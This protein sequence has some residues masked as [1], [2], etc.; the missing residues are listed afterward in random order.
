M[1]LFVEP[2][3]LQ[4]TITGLRHTD[5]QFCLTVYREKILISEQIPVFPLHFK[6]PNNGIPFSQS[7]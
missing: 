6:L 1:A 2:S 4:A 5:F 7:N 3:C